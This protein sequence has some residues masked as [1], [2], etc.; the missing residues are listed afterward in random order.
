MFMPHQSRPVPDFPPTWVS[1]GTA[2]S[3]PPDLIDAVRQV[4]AGQGRHDI[5]NGFSAGR[6]SKY[7][8]P[9][10]HVLF[11][12]RLSPDPFPDLDPATTEVDLPG[13]GRIHIGL[14]DDGGDCHAL[15]AAR[16]WSNPSLSEGV[17]AQDPLGQVWFQGRIQGQSDIVTSRI[18]P[19]VLP[20]LALSGEEGSI[21]P[22]LPAKGR[23]Q[24]SLQGWVLEACDGWVS[25]EPEDADLKSLK[26]HIERFVARQKK[27]TE[28]IER[29]L[30]DERLEALLIG[31]EFP[32]RKGIV[33]AWENHA[34]RQP[35][36]EALGKLSRELM[37]EMRRS[38]LL[39][40]CPNNGP[41]DVRGITSWNDWLDG[42]FDGGP[43]R[44]RDAFFWSEQ[45]LD[46]AP[47]FR[48][49]DA[50]IY[51][52][53]IDARD[54]VRQI[55]T[56]G[57][58]WAS[59]EPD[60][61][62]DRDAF[63]IFKERARAAVLE[64]FI[65]DRDIR[66]RMMSSST[67]LQDHLSGDYLQ[68]QGSFLEPVLCARARG[69]EKPVPL[70]SLD[71]PKVARHLEM[72]LPSGVLVMADW[73][74]IPGFTEAV[75][76]ICDGDR[77][78]IGS[79]AGLDTRAKDYFEKMGL[80]I[81]QVG[82]TSPAAFADTPGIWRMGYVDE[83][84]K[85]FWTSGGARTKL[86]MPEQAWKTCTDLWANIFADREVILDVL[87]VSGLYRDRDAAGSAL[88]NY[89]DT[90]YGV[91]IVELG[92]DKLH[93]YLP[94]GAAELKR[95]FAKEFRA[96]EIK[97]PKWRED[98][99]ILSAE[100]LRVDASLLEDSTWA[101]GRIEVSK[102]GRGQAPENENDPAP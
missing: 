14:V 30:T 76:A 83:D 23:F 37:E 34:H 87:M 99:Y 62:V 66:A 78:E 100:P 92:V 56:P 88:Q 86:A 84:N 25:P 64:S 13:H 65:A 91:S 12:I 50:C 59:D 8:H 54:H 89:A 79:A 2:L 85:A 44:K 63:G 61:P 47:A 97:T 73:L 70:P 93:L 68:L 28:I 15:H 69:R 96:A 95:R 53:D 36:D 98:S 102:A 58:K 18:L 40:R 72:S 4:T 43:D 94:T 38:G 74:R 7:G 9:E 29:H 75:E 22:H 46:E 31:R 19:D 39:A 60:L 90:T 81:V 24:I 45:I 21:L 5:W 55:L 3:L 49:I 6:I 27:V 10:R 67:S 101:E 33:P 11:E 57:A 51:A 1:P 32:I 41:R 80:A 35:F 52:A 42:R 17:I 82:N 48:L 20:V 16:A 26:D 77:Y 71:P